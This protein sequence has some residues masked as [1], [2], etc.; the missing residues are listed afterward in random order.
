VT[1]LPDS[2]RGKDWLLM[3]KM[4][5]VPMLESLVPNHPQLYYAEDPMELD[6]AKVVWSQ[7]P[8]GTKY[9]KIMVLLTG[10]ND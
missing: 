6:A 8:S 4:L 9:I 7:F 10:W 3:H 1:I 5:G 2:K